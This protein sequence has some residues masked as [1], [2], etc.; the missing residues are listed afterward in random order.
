MEAADGWVL[1]MRMGS[2]LVTALL[3]TCAHARR[4]C[5]AAVM[6]CGEIMR[7]A[8][9]RSLSGRGN[10]KG[11]QKEREKTRVKRRAIAGRYMAGMAMDSLCKR[12]AMESGV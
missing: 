3:A 11:R 5:E 9:Q 7:S 8:M 1:D 2:R 12:R 4:L 10:G 6:N